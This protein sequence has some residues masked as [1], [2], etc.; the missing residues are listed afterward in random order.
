MSV[1]KENKNINPINKD[2]I[3]LSNL[4]KILPSEI[5]LRLNKFNIYFTT[6]YYFTFYLVL[7]RRVSTLCHTL[8]A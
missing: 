7:V 8:A 5:V 6:K 1:N 3:F 4:T 2:E